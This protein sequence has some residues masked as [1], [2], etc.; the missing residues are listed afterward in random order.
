MCKQDGEWAP[1]VVKNFTEGLSMETRTGI[2]HETT[3]ASEWPILPSTFS[4]PSCLVGGKKNWDRD[5]DG[6]VT[7]FNSMILDNVDSYKGPNVD[8]EDFLDQVSFPEPA[9]AWS[10]GT[11]SEWGEW[12]T[13]CKR[14]A[15]GCETTID[16]KANKG[17]QTRERECL[18]D[19]L[20]ACYERCMPVDDEGRTPMDSDK[21]KYP[22][23]N[24]VDRVTETDK[25]LWWVDPVTSKKVKSY[26]FEEPFNPYYD[27]DVNWLREQHKQMYA[28][29]RQAGAFLMGLTL[30]QAI[31]P[32][33]F[34]EA[35][36]E[37]HDEAMTYLCTSQMREC[38]AQVA[39]WVHDGPDGEVV[40]GWSEWSQCYA[41]VLPDS[42]TQTE[43][44]NHKCS[45]S[46]NVNGNFA[47]P[48]NLGTHHYQQRTRRCSTGCFADCMA[49]V[50]S[51]TTSFEH[52]KESWAEPGSTSKWM[53]WTKIGDPLY[54]Q[55]GGV[56]WRACHH[57]QLS[58]GCPSDVFG[59]WKSHVSLGNKC[60]TPIPT[61]LKKQDSLKNMNGFLKEGTICSEVYSSMN[62][63]DN[64]P[65]W[66]V[67]AKPNGKDRA[68]KLECKCPGGCNSC[69]WEI[70]SDQNILGVP[71]VMPAVS[72][73]NGY[74][75]DYSFAAGVKHE[76]DY[77]H[78][79]I[80]AKSF[81]FWDEGEFPNLWKADS[82]GLRLC[83]SAKNNQKKQFGYLWSS[84]YHWSLYNAA[85]DID[86]YNW[87]QYMCR[88]GLRFGETSYQYFTET[89]FEIF[90]V[91]DKNTLSWVDANKFM[92]EN[93][94]P[95]QIVTAADNDSGDKDDE[96]TYDGDLSNWRI[97]GACRIILRCSKTMVK[98][99][100]NGKIE[101]PC[102]EEGMVYDVKEGSLR[103]Y[104]QGSYYD[105]VNN[106]TAPEFCCKEAQYLH[107]A[108]P[109]LHGY[110][111][112]EN[113]RSVGG[114]YNPFDDS[115]TLSPM[116]QIWAQSERKVH[117]DKTLAKSIVDD[118]KRECDSENI[119]ILSVNVKKSVTFWSEW[120][121][122]SVSCGTE[123]E[124][125]VWTGGVRTRKRSDI[126][127]N[128]VEGFGLKKQKYNNEQIETEA[129]NE[130][131][132][133]MTHWGEWGEYSGCSKQ[134]DKNNE[135]WQKRKRECWFQGASFSSWKSANKGSK[136]K[137][138]DDVH[139]PKDDDTEWRC[140]CNEQNCL[141]D[142]GNSL[143]P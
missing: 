7:L 42:A 124:P 40:S 23:T 79:E 61:D 93:W 139:C 123:T 125:G 6:Y 75:V 31:F 30:P 128:Y 107:W 136:S 91:E 101:I 98:Q 81:R 133:Q 41:N 32:V 121:S 83:V 22:F 122:C 9:N 142:N 54:P 63:I 116:Q 74:M 84:S 16:G 76:W 108:E 19:G 17:Y 39:E 111:D 62:P 65:Y 112:L 55:R 97:Q 34:I 67:H 18:V 49:N 48:Y 14:A 131:P 3:V 86:W 1:L 105:G 11:W 103:M 21:K 138:L 66:D 51:P 57:E 100:N 29:C 59:G 20:P 118:A 70:I 60:Y 137:T 106:A 46:G 13:T 69:H 56:N 119:Q 5:H 89:D 87:N 140:C 53:A 8:D 15:V 85:K 109:L 77:R 35:N 38:D 115:R 68:V 26:T 134:K 2:F 135:K 47:S 12:T 129:C 92:V 110:G 120:S 104:T 52:F 44:D 45:T 73:L 126:I 95:S 43:R 88:Y 94:D 24:R 36:A 78:D 25:N 127:Q 117:Q 72:H 132:C 50:E 28:E 141:D 80:M 130:G 114:G 58:Y 71:D 96:V 64:A 10:W 102:T 113:T 33:D 99:Y 4:S 37:E 82:E 143:C 27:G 90:Q